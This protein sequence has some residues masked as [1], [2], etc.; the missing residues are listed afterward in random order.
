MRNAV[1]WAYRRQ[2]P[3][4]RNGWL[5]VD[6]WKSRPTT[7][8]FSTPR[9]RVERP[10][11]VRRRADDGGADVRRRRG[12]LVDCSGNTT[13]LFRI[14]QHTDPIPRRHDRDD[15]DGLCRTGRSGTDL[16]RPS[17]PV[18]ISPPNT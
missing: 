3:L 10:A 8:L 14:R 16:H 7:R 18:G 1:N 17:G 6:R 2:G 15:R 9:G 11:T 5:N 13:R 4:P 12:R